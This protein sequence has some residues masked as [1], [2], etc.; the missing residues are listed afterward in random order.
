MASQGCANEDEPRLLSQQAKGWDETNEANAKQQRQ[1]E[2]LTLANSRS[3]PRDRIASQ[4]RV[5]VDGR[6]HG[7]APDIF[8]SYAR[9]DERRAREL[10]QALAGKG[11]AVFWDR[12]IPPG[13][14]WH[15]YIGEAL[16]TAKCIVVVWSTSSVRSDWVLE[17]A[18]EGK[19]RG[20]LIPVRV[21]KVELP[22][23]FRFV[24]AADLCDWELGVVTDELEH[25][26]ESIRIK[27]HP[28]EGEPAG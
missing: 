27:V 3:P 15:N 9:Q 13:R 23:G 16:S 22:F 10:A 19:A 18:Q 11:Y 7:I 25:L 20:V 12:R 24:Q 28:V 4:R 2:A 1:E 26:L 5:L 8:L 21:E 17:E 6:A 14:T